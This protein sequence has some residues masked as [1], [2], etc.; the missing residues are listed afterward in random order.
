MP[1]LTPNDIHTAAETLSRLTEYLHAEPDP[2]EALA[3]IEPLL[4]EYTGIPVQLGDALRAL[5]RAVLDHPDTPRT[6]GLH[7]LVAE[8]RDAAWEQTDQH[9]LHYALDDLRALLTGAS[10]NT[11][12]CSACR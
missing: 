10:S 1:A 3:L 8:L 4:D 11:P 7:R 5:A 12:E 6:P 9:T 2:G